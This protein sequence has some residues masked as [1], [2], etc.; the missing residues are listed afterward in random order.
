MMFLLKASI[1]VAVVL[2]ALTFGMFAALPDSEDST[3]PAG[4][5]SHQQLEVDRLM[6]QRMGTE[7]QMPMGSDGMLGRSAD[8]AYVRA[9]EQHA[10]EIDRMLGR[11]P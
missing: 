8:P 11:A 1:T 5:F 10:S 6:T 3:S 4:G 9:L 7:A 2:L